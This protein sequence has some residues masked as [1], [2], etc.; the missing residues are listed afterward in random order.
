[1]NLDKAY[2]SQI[3]IKKGKASTMSGI[4]DLRLVMDDGVTEIY[5]EEAITR[6]IISKSKK[7]NILGS[8]NL[9]YEHWLYYLNKN[10]R[11]VVSR[12]NARDKSAIPEL[13]K[14]AKVVEAGLIPNLQNLSSGELVLQCLL[15]S[16]FDP[17][18]AHL[19]N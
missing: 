17:V 8:S 14:I 7:K 19:S 16:Y 2:D 15:F 18:K 1:M 12:V 10:V 9:G 4:F 13:K 11:E 3:P 6:Y 5:G